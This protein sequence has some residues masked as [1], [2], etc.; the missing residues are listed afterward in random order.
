MERAGFAV[1]DDTET[2]SSWFRAGD[3]ASFHL[4]GVKP[5]QVPSPGPT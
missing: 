4:V 5:A 3:D 1:V 2:P